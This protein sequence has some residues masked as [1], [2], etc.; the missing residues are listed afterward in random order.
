L[1]V[2]TCS[3]LSVS[4]QFREDA[5]KANRVSGMVRR[6]FR[7]LDSQSFLIIYKGYVSMRSLRICYSSLVTFYLQ[8]DTD[9][10]KKIQRRATK[11]MTGF[12]KLPY[13]LRL[14]KLKLTTLEKKRLR[15]DL[16]ET[17]KKMAKK[18]LTRVVSSY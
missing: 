3:D 5:S 9:C 16:I 8:I 7:E 10:L 17:Y 15:R 13:E 18:K 2:L 11:M 1:G 14:K 6:Q 4:R 12:H